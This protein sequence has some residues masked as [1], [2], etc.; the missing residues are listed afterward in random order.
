MGLSL[1]VRVRFLVGTRTGWFF[2]SRQLTNVGAPAGRRSAGLSPTFI[3]TRL[4]PDRNNAANKA[5]EFLSPGYID[6]NYG[7]IR[8]PAL[9][10]QIS[11]TYSAWINHDTF[12]S[13]GPGRHHGG[14]AKMRPPDQIG[15][16]SF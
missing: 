15:L 11:Y 6:N 7:E 14:T 16:D 3:H 4:A 1:A 5:F 10:N 9:T 12:Q 8:L 13:R 2:P